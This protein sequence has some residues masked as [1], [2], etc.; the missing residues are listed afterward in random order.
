MGVIPDANMRRLFINLLLTLN[1]M[2]PDYDFSS[3][4]P[5]E[6]MEEVNHDLVA[7]SINSSL[8]KAMM[9]EPSLAPT[10]WAGV[11]TI[12]P[13]E[14]VIFSY[15]PSAEETPLSESCIW[16]FN[17]FFYNKELKRVL[18]LT[19]SCT[20]PE[21]PQ[22]LEEEPFNSFDEDN[23]GEQMDFDMDDIY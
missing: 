16:S 3:V 14:C 5:E 19:C 17:Y 20:R 4:R 18:F 21:M 11:E 10:L 12:K 2:F 9:L 1:T 15:I 13:S 22:S 8:Q 7:H 23:T 6:F